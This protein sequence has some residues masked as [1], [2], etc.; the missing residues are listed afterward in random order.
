MKAAVIRT[1][2]DASVLTIQEQPMPI[3]DDDG[4][5]IKIAAASIN[6]I[7]W[8]IRQGLAYPIRV[9]IGLKLP[10]ILGFD[11]CGEIVAIGNKVKTWKVG[12]WVIARSNHPE[13]RGYA[14]YISLHEDHIVAKPKNLSPIEASTIPL[15]GLTALQALRDHGKVAP[16][17]E[18][19]IIGASGSV[20]MF[21]VQ[22][23]KHFGAIVTAV[24]STKNLAFAKSLH[25]D[26]VIDYTQSSLFDSNKKYDVIF[27]AV[28]KHRFSQVKNYLTPH[29]KFVTTV[30]NGETPFSF[31]TNLFSPQKNCFVLMKNRL[32]DLQELA[33]LAEQQK[34]ITLVDSV[35]PLEKVADAHLKSQSEHACGKIV[36]DIACSQNQT[37]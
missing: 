26:F 7:D 27:D 15:A 9:I 1:Y 36:L 22:I 34:I 12:D 37:K 28:G 21:A 6:P 3:C 13:G 35:Y 4:V 10:A 29:G 2:G 19:M 31:I 8:K 5:L 18:V 24:C 11:I 14:E 32:A 25:A 23:A 16:G 20:G 17:Q 30:P 33:T